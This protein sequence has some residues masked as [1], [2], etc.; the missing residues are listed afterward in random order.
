MSAISAN[1]RPLPKSLSYFVSKL[2]GYRRSCVKLLP[3]Q[4]TSVSAS[5]QLRVVIPRGLGLA[6]F[7]T[8]LLCADLTVPTLAGG[9]FPANIESIIKSIQ[10]SVA[11][12]QIANI[13]EYNHLV[14]TVLNYT[15]GSEATFKGA[16]NQLRNPSRFT[17]PALIAGATTYTVAIPLGTSF[18]L[19]F[20]PQT[21]PLALSGDVE[22]TI[23][24]ANSYIQALAT[25]PPAWSLANVYMSLDQIQFSDS[26]YERMLMNAV[27]GGAVLELPFS[28]AVQTANA[29][30]SLSTSTRFTCSTGSLDMI[31]WKPISQTYDSSAVNTVYSGT[32]NYF[33]ALGS[34]ITSWQVLVNGNSIPSFEISKGLTPSYNTNALGSTG[35]LLGGHQVYDANSANDLFAGFVRLNAGTEADSRMLSGLKVVCY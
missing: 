35:D 7:S 34:S 10:V 3:S 18:G 25:A 30:S 17:T 13:Q 15:C 11:G 6:D 29:V 9:G 4:S 31:V 19:D 26:S 24:L 32:T 12:I 23:Q 22:I 21:F 2:Q 20:K 28:N 16:L 27:D 5:G 14:S 8:M 1:P 33:R